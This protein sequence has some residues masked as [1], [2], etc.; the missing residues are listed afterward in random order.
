MSEQATKR[1]ILT[2]YVDM[3]GVQ[4][5]VGDVVICGMKKQVIEANKIPDMKSLLLGRKIGNIYDT[6]DILDRVFI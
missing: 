6:P 3:D 1:K 5:Y 2:K 4:L